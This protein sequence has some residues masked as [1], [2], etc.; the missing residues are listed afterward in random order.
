M[1]ASVKLIN[2]IIKSSKGNKIKN[3]H[4]NTTNNINSLNTATKINNKSQLLNL[5]QSNPKMKQAIKL[6]VQHHKINPIHS[7]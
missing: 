7:L 3:T 1:N 5:I 6:I 2:E 4:D